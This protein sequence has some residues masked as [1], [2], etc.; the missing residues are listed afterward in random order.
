MTTMWERKEASLEKA[1]AVWGCSNMRGRPPECWL[2]KLQKLK[3]AGVD[4]SAVCNEKLIGITNN[5]TSGGM[6]LIDESSSGY[7]DSYDDYIA[8]KR[9]DNLHGTVTHEIECIDELGNVYF[10]LRTVHDR[11]RRGEIKVA[12]RE[13]QKESV[14]ARKTKKE[15]ETIVQ[16]YQ[17]AN[18]NRALVATKVADWA[19]QMG[20]WPA[21]KR[22]SLIAR[23]KRG[24][25]T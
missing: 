11:V 19:L 5:S 10:E 17:D 8:I 21:N 24:F 15:T 4:T 14:K 7:K 6:G 1:D 23:L 13:S 25:A 18:N 2:T 20:L 12:R 16:K 22:R 9:H 3:A